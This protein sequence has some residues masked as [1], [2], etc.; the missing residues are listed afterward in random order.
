MEL[1]APK[2]QDDSKISRAQ[3]IISQISY[4]LVLS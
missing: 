3:P 2:S 4:K 1:Q